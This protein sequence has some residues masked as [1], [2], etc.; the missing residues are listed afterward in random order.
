VEVVDWLLLLVEVLVLLAL[1]VGVDRIFVV[2]CAGWGSGPNTGSVRSGRVGA[3]AVTHEARGGIIPSVGV[4]LKRSGSANFETPCCQT[5]P[6]RG[7]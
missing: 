5:G 1:L 2:V 3:M 6:E 7:F 4:E